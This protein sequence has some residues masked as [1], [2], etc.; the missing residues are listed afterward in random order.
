MIT[1]RHLTLL[2]LAALA[3]GAARA[4]S[5]D[6]A[7]PNSATALTVAPSGSGSRVRLVARGMIP[8]Y[9]AYESGTDLVIDMPDL[10]QGA[11]PAQTPGAGNVSGMELAQTETPLENGAVRHLLRL[12]IRR[13]ARGAFRVVKLGDELIVVSGPLGSLPPV[14]PHERMNV[15]TTEGD[16]V[17][18]KTPAD[19]IPVPAPVASLDASVAAG[20]AVATPAASPSAPVLAPP[21]AVVASKPAS[22]RPARHLTNIRWTDG[23]L[24]MDAD[25]VLSPVTT[26]LENPPRLAIDLPDVVEHSRTRSLQVNR[27]GVKAVRVGQFQPAP[28]AV[29]RVV[30]D[31]EHPLAAY[32]SEGTAKGALLKIDGAPRSESPA[33]AAAPVSAPAV[34]DALQ[35]ASAG[36]AP[37]AADAPA[38][39]PALSVLPPAAAPAKVAKVEVKD[40]DAQTANAIFANDTATIPLEVRQQLRAQSSLYETAD[41]AGAALSAPSAGR[42]NFQTKTLEDPNVRYTGRPISLNFKEADVLDV[43]R[44]FQEISHLN[45]IA[46]PSV[47]GT[48]TVF[49]E[50][51]PWDQAMDIILRNLGLDYIYSNN[52]IWIAPQSEILAQQKQFADRLEQQ[53]NVEQPVTKVKRISYAKAADL[54]NI[55]SK[56]LSKKGS[57]T[58]DDRTNQMIMSEIPSNFGKIEKLLTLLDVPSAQV[59]LEARIVEANSNFS[60]TFGISLGGRWAPRGVKYASDLDATSTKHDVWSSNASATPI[61][62]GFPNTVGQFGSI[63]PGNATTGFL[64]LIFSNKSG[65]FH[66]DTLINAQEARGR[67]KLLSS[68]SI[69]VEDNAEANISAGQEFAFTTCG[70]QN[71]TITTKTAVLSLKIKPQITSDG[72]VAMEIDLSNDR[73]DLANFRTVGASSSLPIFRRSAKTRLRVADGD[74]AVIGGVSSVDEGVSQSGVPVLSKIP[75]LGW[76]FK[77][78][79]RN[80]S[81]AELL[82]FITPKILR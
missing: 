25:G 71:C 31:L 79:S 55:L 52:V 38:P 75:V 60:D 74:T 82:I 57:I 68:P 62:G 24:V 6:A 46:H 7:A 61:G 20:A 15:I 23:G 14:E 76:L 66:L 3:T 13:S 36:P 21:P 50:N 64:D 27:D 69:A 67:A 72:N 37:P 42:G 32:Q 18:S 63:N 65:S 34:T 10:A 22:G 19:E 12:T 47:K 41:S 43:I 45:F 39:A 4:A 17:I 9:T 5:A 16:K 53:K 78:R 73:L 40:I 48:V 81:N 26:A 70:G 1:L 59:R 30:L 51:V 49:L 29:A 80:R 8:D 56:S 33:V 44:Y 2:G 77:N 28:N 11:L 35:A 54:S 58:V